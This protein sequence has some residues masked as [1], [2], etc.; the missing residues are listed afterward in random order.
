MSFFYITEKTSSK[1]DFFPQN[2]P[3]WGVLSKFGGV[4]E[5]N[6]GGKLQIRIQRPQ[7]HLVS[8]KTGL[9]LI[10]PGKILE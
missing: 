9:P 6:F 8:Q 1:K 3:F 2:P 5:G 4:A 7:K 10:F